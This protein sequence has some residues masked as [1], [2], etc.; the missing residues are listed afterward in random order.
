MQKAVIAKFCSPNIGRITPSANLD[1]FLQPVNVL[2]YIKSSDRTI[3]I[4]KLCYHDNSW[5]QN[6]KKPTKIPRQYDQ[7]KS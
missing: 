2:F 1:N 5:T 7:K 6:Q 4:S 3:V